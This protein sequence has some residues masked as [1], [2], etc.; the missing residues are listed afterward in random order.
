MLSRIIVK[1]KLISNHQLNFQ[2]KHV[3][4]EEIYCRISNDMEI[5]RY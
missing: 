1:H 5:D 4:I 2:Y 3:T